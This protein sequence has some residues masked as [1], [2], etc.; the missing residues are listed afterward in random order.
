MLKQVG[1]MGGNDKYR[2]L[3]KKIFKWGKQMFWELEMIG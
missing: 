3:K 2:N 1:M